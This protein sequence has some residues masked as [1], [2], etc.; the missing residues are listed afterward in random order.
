MK[1]EDIKKFENI[2]FNINT[3]YFKETY[4][5]IDSLSLNKGLLYNS[6]YF[7][8]IYFSHKWNSG[9]N[10]IRCKNNH[11]EYSVGPISLEYVLK[12][13]YSFLNNECKPILFDYFH[14]FSNDP[15]STEFKLDMSIEKDAIAILKNN[16]KYIITREQENIDFKK[17]YLEV[18][19]DS[20]AQPELKNI[21]ELDDDFQHRNIGTLFN[22]VSVKIGSEEKIPL[23][24]FEDLSDSFVYSL[25]YNISYSLVEI[26]SQNNLDISNLDDII[27]GDGVK[28]EYIISTPKKIYNK[29]AVYYFQ[30]ALSSE[31]LVLKFLSY[32]QCLEYFYLNISDKETIKNVKNALLTPVFI[33]N[34]EGYSDVQI[35]NIIDIV[36]K[37]ET[38]YDEKISLR[39]LLN[40]F[41]DTTILVNELK[42]HGANISNDVLNNNVIFANA[43]SLNND[44]DGN[45]NINTLAKRIYKVRNSLVHSKDGKEYSYEP[46]NKKHEKELRN[47]VFLIRLVAE[48]IIEGTAKEIKNSDIV[49]NSFSENLKTFLP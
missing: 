43:P 18:M 27:R 19:G 13:I 37:K 48:Q 24:L 2:G 4:S 47:E 41:L 32:Y 26:K 35:K 31:N 40:E 8:K 16:I 34:Y 49:L 42:R 23:N 21:E 9:L 5:K 6:N 7:E 3:N 28:Q 45:I 15:S 20:N 11:F 44:P 25:G 29:K 30:Q 22:V 46:F 38:N 33:D 39:L 1:N 10:K 17:L 12:S 14:D 36:R